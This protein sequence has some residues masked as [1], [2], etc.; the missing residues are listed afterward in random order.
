[1]ALLALSGAFDCVSMVIR[2]TLVQLL[3][4]PAMMGRVQSV[5]TMFVISSNEIGAFESGMAAQLMGLVPSVVAGGVATLL[6]VAATA[7][8]SPKFRRTVVQSDGSIT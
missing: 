5:S 3:T 2:S 7:T 6:V 1:M 8:L 4:P